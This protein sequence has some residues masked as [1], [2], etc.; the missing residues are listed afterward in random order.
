[1]GGTGGAAGHAAGGSVGTG[2]SGT[3]TN[4]AS[5]ANNCGTCGHSCQGGAC[6]SG[7]CQ[8]LLLGTVPST[9]EYAHQTTVSGG[10]VYVFTGDGQ[11]NPSNVWQVD[12]STPGTPSEVKTSGTVSCLMNGELFWMTSGQGF[13]IASCTITSCATTAKPIVTLPSGQY[14]QTGLGCDAVNN[15]LIWA[16]TADGLSF[17][18]NRSSPAGTN[19]R[20]ITS[21]TFPDNYWHVI[22]GGQF[23]GGT[24]RLFY[25]HYDFS[26]ST[27]YRYYVS[28][29]ALNAAGV[30][31]VK[32]QN[33]GLGPSLASAPLD[34]AN[35]T[36]LLVSEYSTAGAYSILSIPLPNGIISGSV[37]V[38]S[39]G[40]IYGGVL[41]ST[42]FFGTVWSSATIPQDAIIR[43]PLSGCSNPVIMARGQAMASNFADDGSAIYWTTTGQG[44]NVAIW[45]IAK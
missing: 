33:V 9:T 22:D 41:D 45:K 25:E 35:D 37:P 23:T 31:L 1:M 3:C 7:A 2:G 38:F 28:T 40:Y 34:L 11:N 6:S 30:Q 12:A 5:D 19:A 44:S 17:T 27:D 20:P 24:D 15:E 21:L 42:N 16:S 29:K 39:D 43:C 10:K 13:G 4:T 26:A 32:V 36:V 14:F 18:I 8:P